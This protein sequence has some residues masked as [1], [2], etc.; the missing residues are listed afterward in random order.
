M[1]A[2]PPV[3]GFDY[4]GNPKNW[5]KNIV[6]NAL[7]SVHDDT[8]RDL[9]QRATALCKSESLT[10]EGSQFK[11]EKKS[12]ANLEEAR[13]VASKMLL[14]ESG[15]SSQI[16][17]YP[18]WAAMM[19]L[20]VIKYQA[21]S[22]MPSK[23]HATPSSQRSQS[24][25]ETSIEFSPGSSVTANLKSLPLF[26]S[27]FFSTQFGLNIIPARIGTGSIRRKLILKNLPGLEGATKIEFAKLEFKAL[28]HILQE[29]GMYSPDAHTLQYRDGESK[30]ELV[31]DRDFQNAIYLATCFGQNSLD[32]HIDEP[33]DL[34]TSF[35]LL[36][37]DEM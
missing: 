13:L 23:T 2:L 37:C 10:A 12:R 17:G 7:G 34:G 18:N 25:V 21:A 28:R 1:A 9:Y 8:I 36:S 19:C 30:A 14:N 33:E 20:G 5:T 27:E 4:N 15:S 3:T 22:G 32:I 29:D 11:G 6:T 16:D 31:N 24:V 35:F 26:D